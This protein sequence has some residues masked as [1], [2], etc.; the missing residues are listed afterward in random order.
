[1]KVYATNCR[2]VK[3]RRCLPSC[4]KT[5][6]AL[7]VLLIC[8][9]KLARHWLLLLTSHRRVATTGCASPSLHE[10]SKTCFGIHPMRP[11]WRVSVRCL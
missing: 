3:C 5:W 1:M 8:D 4:S 9:P 10:S 11:L 2:G 6:D 7:L